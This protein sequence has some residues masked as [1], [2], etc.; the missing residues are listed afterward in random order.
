MMTANRSGM[1]TGGSDGQYIL[2]PVGRPQYCVGE[3]S[4]D[5]PTSALLVFLVVEHLVHLCVITYS[6]HK[7]LHRSS[8]SRCIGSITAR[9]W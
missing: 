1:W 7:V 8:A 6:L 3:A 5:I 4:I 2:G 9:A